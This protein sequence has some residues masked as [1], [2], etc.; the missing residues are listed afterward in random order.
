[1]DPLYEKITSE[2]VL[3]NPLVAT[4]IVENQIDLIIWTKGTKITTS[5]IC[6]DT[7]AM[8]RKLGYVLHNYGFELKSVFEIIVWDM[9]YESIENGDKNIKRYYNKETIIDTL[10]FADDEGAV[11]ID[12]ITEIAEE[13][14]KDPEYIEFIDY[15][16][17][18]LWEIIVNKHAI[19]AIPYKWINENCLKLLIGVNHEALSSTS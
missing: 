3:I 7:R 17:S 11:S 19:A 16:I 9:L 2:M 14:H 13:L 6:L 8:F 10:A 5:T 18:N 4:N 12:K 15:I 1:M